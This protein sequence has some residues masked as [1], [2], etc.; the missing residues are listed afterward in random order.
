M[1]FFDL[2]SMFIG[3]TGPLGSGKGE[4]AKI[5]QKEGFKYI[6]LSDVVRDEST[7]R[8]LSHSR[9]NLQKIGN[10]LRKKYGAGILGFRVVMD[11]MKGRAKDWV[12][13][14]IRNPA[15]IKELSMMPGFYLIGVTADKDILVKRILKRKRRGDLK[16]RKA[17]LKKLELESGKGQ[18]EKGLQIAKCISQADFLILNDGALA[19]LS[20]KVMH[21]LSLLNLTDRP[22]FDEI[23]MELAYTWAKR[24]TCLRRQ[25]GAVIAKD[26]QQLTAGYNGAPR[27]LPHCADLGGCLREKLGIPSGQRHEICRGTHAEQNAI[28]QA[29]KFGIDISGGTLYCNTHPCV[30]CTKM[31][32]NAGIDR[33]VYDFDYDD[34]LAKEI[35]GQQKVLKLQRYEGVR[36]VKRSGNWKCC[37]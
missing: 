29:A 10:D 7:K 18:P 26:K 30:I 36:F 22:T 17:I 8:K 24:A 11:I 4:I 5:L 9:E 19:E 21:F 6:S 20:K 28:T 13:D 31:I 37:L 27:G 32:I 25:V 23:F 3:L 16:T 2:I 12:I 33:V 15:E 14:G 1:Q 34:P 35:L